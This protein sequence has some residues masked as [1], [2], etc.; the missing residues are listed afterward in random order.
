MNIVEAHS[1][2][3]SALD[4]VA[5]TIAAATRPLITPG[6]YEVVANIIAVVPLPPSSSGFMAS[7]TR[8]ISVGINASR[9]II[10]AD[11]QDAFWAVFSSDAAEKRLTISG[12][13]RNVQ[14]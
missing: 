2:L 3:E 4:M 13:D 7:A 8:P 12:P 11:S 10:M 14:K 6:A 1:R 9:P 5:E